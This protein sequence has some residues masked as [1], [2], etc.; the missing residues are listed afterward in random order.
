MKNEKQPLSCYRM[1]TNRNSMKL[2]IQT[3]KHT[4]FN[5]EKIVEKTQIL[6]FIKRKEKQKQSK[7]R[8]DDKNPNNKM[9]T[10][11]YIYNI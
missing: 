1:V 8:N 3:Q 11:K 6:F 7:K 4:N 10:N 9:T 2:N 5:T